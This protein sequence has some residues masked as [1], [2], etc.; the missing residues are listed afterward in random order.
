[1]KNRSAHKISKYLTEIYVLYLVKK[2]FTF[3]LI[4]QRERQR[5][6]NFLGKN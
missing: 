2:L 5:Y 6:P 4:F 3:E 1:M